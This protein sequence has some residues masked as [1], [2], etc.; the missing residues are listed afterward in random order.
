[1]P[2]INIKE[3]DNTIV[4]PKSSNQLIVAVPINSKDGPADRWVQMNTYDEFIQTFGPNPDPNGQFGNSWEYAANLLMREMTVMVRRITNVLNEDGTNTSD[5]LPGVATAKNI[6]KVASLTNEANS[7]DLNSLQESII[8]VRDIMGHSVLSKSDPGVSVYISE[9][10]P[11]WEEDSS[12][13]INENTKLNEAFDSIYGLETWTQNH[14]TYTPL[15]RSPQKLPIGIGCFTDVNDNG[16]SYPYIET[17]HEW[18]ALGAPIVNPNYKFELNDGASTTIKGGDEITR[19]TEFDGVGYTDF[20]TIINQNNKGKT[21]DFY[22]IKDPDAENPDDADI[23]RVDSVVNGYDNPYAHK[24]TASDYLEYAANLAYENTINAKVNN[25]VIVK[26]SD[27]NNT[28]TEWKP[29]VYTGCKFFSTEDSFQKLA[30]SYKFVTGD[31]VFIRNTNYLYTVTVKDVSGAKEYTLTKFAT[32]V[33]EEADLDKVKTDE[34]KFAFVYKT[35]TV[36]K[37]DTDWT[38]TNDTV[39]TIDGVIEDFDIAKTLSIVP[40]NYYIDTVYKT[41][42]E[43]KKKA[44]NHHGNFAYVE[45][46][47]TIWQYDNTK[48]DGWVNTTWTENKLNEFVVLSTESGSVEITKTNQ[49]GKLVVIPW[50]KDVDGVQNKGRYSD[51]LYWRI[52]TTDDKTHYLKILFW[53]NSGNIIGNR[54]KETI[55]GANVIINN[56]TINANADVAKTGIAVNVNRYSDITIEQDALSNR[57]TSGIPSI[58]NTSRS[59]LKIY[60]LRL[61]K[62]NN[63]GDSVLLYNAGIERIKTRAD[64]ITSDPLVKITET[65]GDV[66][67][68]SS[69]RP[70]LDATSVEERWY[71]ELP[72]GATLSYQANISGLQFIVE[73][74]IFDDSDV[75][76]SLFNSAYGRYDLC[77]STS[78]PLEIIKT[79]LPEKDVEATLADTEIT[80]LPITD[81]RGNY[82]LFVASYN[83]P[84]SNGNSIRVSIRTI[85][86]QGIYAYVYRNTQ[87]LERIELCPFRVRQSNGRVKIYDVNLDKEHIW[88]T[89]LAKFGIAIGINDTYAIP[90]PLTGAYVTLELNNLIPD[91]N[92]Y[93]Y[94]DALIGVDSSKY[95]NLKFGKDPLDDDVIHEVPYAYDILKDKYKYDISFVSNGA[96]IDKIV[97][98]SDIMSATATSD[99]V[100]LIEDAMLDLAETRQDCVAYLDIPYDVAVEDVPSYYEHISSSY[101]AAYDPWCQINL[102]TGSAKWMPP[103]FVQLYTHAKSIASGNKSYLPPAGVRRALVP[104]IVRTSHEL[105]SSYIT[106][107]QNGESAQFINPIIWLNGFDYSIYGQKTLYNIVNQ[108]E[109]YESALQNL[110]VRLVANTIKKLIFKTCVELTFE[111]NNIMTWN[112]FKSKLEPHLSVMQGEGTITTYEILMGVETM[113]SADLNSGHVVGTVRV[114]IVNAATDWD[115]NFEIQPNEITFYENDYNSAYTG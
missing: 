88:K 3:Y 92:T 100:R 25:F 49:F 39:I 94:I 83:N 68:T 72:A 48:S 69:L 16:A 34:V 11:A 56:L 74:A 33:A 85:K 81:G 18:N 99:D 79:A 103:S 102:A 98:S 61:T 31:V 14:E 84:G 107:W 110:N 42:V 10:V 87:Y 77:F 82:N 9:Y 50:V 91:Y 115:I 8:G 44:P 26:Y 37:F 76:F 17:A 59:P 7:I 35:K 71:I 111:L 45:S 108:S 24:K 51:K 43:L 60:S 6:I 29:W 57:L 112:E 101:A 40:N 21:G 78:D 4:G 62:K 114:A 12:G 95:Y 89:L 30:S 80:N 32:L 104:E 2:Y 75:V 113:T 47:G 109:M 55:I 65:N 64:S 97:S 73:A 27:A 15:D 90:T 46:T 5:L 67:G 70:Q 54:T 52:A 22:L 106:T 13:T 36:Y 41:D 96:Y 20:D 38:N 93:D 53:T 105:P 23:I 1:M 63:N 66:L 19:D 28:A 58:T 86:N